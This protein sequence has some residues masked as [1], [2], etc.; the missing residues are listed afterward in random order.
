MSA[1]LQALIGA[2]AVGHRTTFADAKVK[3]DAGR[4]HSVK[5]AGAN[6]HLARR[7]RP[8]RAAAMSLVSCEPTI[9]LT[10]PAPAV[11]K[12]LLKANLSLDDID[13]FEVNEAFASVVLRFMRE[14]GAPEEKIN[15][16]GGAIALGHPIGAT[17]SMLVSTLLDELERRNQKRGVCTLCIGGGMGVAT[18]H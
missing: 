4:T 14:S 3:C 11:A 12:L 13:L 10:A 7:Q 2:L 1:D 8:L 9:M 16:N 5:N 18:A 6:L 15:V 17:G